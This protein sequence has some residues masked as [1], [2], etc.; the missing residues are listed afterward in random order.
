MGPY[1]GT[2]L[3]FCS[4]QADTSLYCETIDTGLVHHVVCVLTPRLLHQY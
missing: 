3:R 2:D 1:G 4:P